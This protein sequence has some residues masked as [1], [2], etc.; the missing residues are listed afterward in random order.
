MKRWTAPI[1]INNPWMVVLFSL[2]EVLVVVFVIY[3]GFFYA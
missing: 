2:V 1:E 3:F